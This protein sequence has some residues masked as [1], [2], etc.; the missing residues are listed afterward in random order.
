MAEFKEAVIEFGEIYV[1]DTVENFP[2]PVEKV[3]HQQFPS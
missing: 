2:Y 1:E 3:E